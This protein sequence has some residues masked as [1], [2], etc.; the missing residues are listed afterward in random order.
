MIEHKRR[1]TA[2]LKDLHLPDGETVEEQTIK[3]LAAGTSS[4]VTLWQGYH[5]NGYLVYTI[6]KDK[7]TVSQNSGVRIAALD[8]RTCENTTYFGVIED[9]WEV[10]YSSN[11]QIPVFRCRWVKHP[12][13][14]EVDGYGLTVVDLNNIGYK[15]DQWVL[16]S[17]VAQVLYIADPTKKTK[18][19][20]V[21]GKQNII[22]VEGIDDVEEYN[23]YD[24]MNLFTDLPQKIK[25]IEAGI[26]KR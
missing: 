5:I 16:A 22:G 13:G 19:V 9:I 7:K 8:E 26:R 11:I 12:K 20:V 6:A 18:H 17:Q 23:Q 15:D 24:Q 21:P 2:W 1:L 4:Q 3:R 14:V 25:I 10:H